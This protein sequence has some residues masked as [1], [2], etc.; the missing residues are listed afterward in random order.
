MKHHRHQSLA[1]VAICCLLASAILLWGSPVALAEET[2]DAKTTIQELNDQLSD[3]RAQQQAIEEQIS[4]TQSQKAQEL[5]NKRALASQ[6]DIARQEAELL[7]QKIQLLEGE[8]DRKEEE[9]SQLEETIE[10]NYDLYKERLRAMYKTGGVGQSGLAA[11][12]GAEDFGEM[13][14]HTQVMSRVA[15]HDTQLLDQLTAD[16]DQLDQAKA[17]LDENKAEL[18]S[19]KQALEERQAQL[20]SEITASEGKIQSYEDAEAEFMA[21][22]D[23]LVAA[24]AALQA[25]LNEIFASMGNTPSV[26][27][28]GELI[29]PIPGYTKITSPYGSRFGGSDFHTGIDIT[30]N[31]PGEIYGKTVLAANGGTVNTV[32]YAPNA[33][34][35]YVI[36]DH[37]GGFAT[38]YAH[39]SSIDVVEG[40]TVAKG[41]PIARAGSSGWSTG[42]HLH[43][44]IRQGKQSQDPALFFNLN[45]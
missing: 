29:W 20:G 33:Y 38:L 41:D 5:A 24:R 30:G 42:A 21:R 35:H 34:G 17:E 25:E 9:I 32:A 44:E 40:Q 10:E 43:F 2:E 7:A 14:I 3:L 45:V 16:K 26:Y 22:K 18:D 1:S 39:C 27:V 12:L 23:E 8:I 11:L 28:G 13:L 4:Q 36:I 6:L 37:G 31:I 15:E 19:S